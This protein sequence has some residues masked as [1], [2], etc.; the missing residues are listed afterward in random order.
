LLV[1]VVTNDGFVQLSIGLVD[2][3]GVVVPVGDGVAVGVDDVGGLVGVVL[4]LVRVG[5]GVGV[6][7]VGGLVGVAVVVGVGVV[8]CAGAA[9]KS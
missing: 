7:V 8:G 6:L 3:V 5:V 4:V 1:A 9:A 2:D